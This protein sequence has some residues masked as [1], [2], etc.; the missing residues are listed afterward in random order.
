MSSISTKELGI[1]AIEPKGEYSSEAYYEKLNTV[2][3]NDSTYM[4]LKSSTGVLPTNTEYWQLIGGGVTKEYINKENYYDEITCTKGREY[5]TDYYLTTIPVRDKENKQINL[6]VGADENLTPLEYAQ[7]NHT[8]LTTNGYL[9]IGASKPMAII[10][11]GVIVQQQYADYQNVQSGYCYI[12]FKAD[13]SVSSYQANETTAQD[14]LDDGVINAFLVYYKIIDDG[15][16]VDMTDIELADSVATLPLE[17]HPRQ[18]IGVKSDGTILIL[19]ND[20]RTDINSGMTSEETANIL[21]DLGCVNAWNMDGGGSTST[22]INGSK[23]NRN[24]DGNGTKDRKIVYTLNAKKEIIIEDIANAFSKI[25]EEKQNL[26]Q[27]IIP[28]IND[29]YSK[30]TTRYLTSVDLDTLIGE[31]ILAYCNGGTNKPDSPYGGYDTGF[32]FINLP[33]AQS[34]Y[35]DL[36]NLQFFIRRDYKE[37]WSRRQVNGTFT[38]WWCANAQNKAIFEAVIGSSSNNKILADN[39]YQNI[40]FK[41]NLSNNNFIKPDPTSVDAQTEEFTKILTDSVGYANVRVTGTIQCV[42][43][44]AKY[45]KIMLGGADTSAVYSFNADTTGRYNFSLETLQRITSNS[46]NTFE[47][48]MYGATGDYIQRCN[49]VVDFDR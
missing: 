11:N 30:I 17:K 43:T 10:Q 18:C 7:K 32:Y 49:C 44:G 35:K 23:I 28:Y 24:I 37:I 42:S 39:T 31:T 47:I 26:I 19:T 34:Q 4:A 33:H 9:Y 5:D 13:R 21:L 48:K 6:Y 2:I 25:G 3:Y 12:G 27:Q 20:G 1:V 40:I 16:I 29:I 46:G 15:T 36:Y 38:D 14:M 8:S 22:I 45:F 41:T